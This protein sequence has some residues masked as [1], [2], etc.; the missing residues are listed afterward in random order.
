MKAIILTLVCIITGSGYEGFAQYTRFTLSGT[1]TYEKSV[2][3]YEIIDKRIDK[4]NESFLGPAF[5]TYKKSYPKIKKMTSTLDFN[6]DSS[7]YTPVDNG[8][9][10]PQAFLGEDPAADQ[11]NIIFS[12]LTAGTFI[13]QKKIPGQ[14]VLVQDSSRQIAWKITDELREIAGYTCRRANAIILDSIYVVAFYTDRIPI[15]G[16]PESFGG[17]PG[18]ILGVALPHQHITWF[19]TRVLDRPIPAANL[20]RPAKGIPAGSSELPD[21]IKTSVKGSE[22]YARFAWFSYQL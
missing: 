13:C 22:R 15:P 16:G 3:I 14:T 2:N 10:D 20:K 4:N 11:P 5:E 19:A 17:L 21:L 9:N 8:I 7:L 12:D 6:R 1:I 18:M